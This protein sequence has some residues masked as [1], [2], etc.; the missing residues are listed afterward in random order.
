LIFHNLIKLL[1]VT[2][3]SLK[4]YGLGFSIDQKMKKLLVMFY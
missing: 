3:H 4:P 1:C 2:Y